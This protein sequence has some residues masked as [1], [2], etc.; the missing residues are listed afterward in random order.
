MYITIKLEPS[1]HCIKGLNKIYQYVIL[2][3][4]FLF[5]FDEHFQWIFI[6]IMHYHDISLFFY[7]RQGNFDEFIVHLRGL[8]NIYNLSGDRYVETSF[9]FLNLKTKKKMEISLLTL[10]LHC[11][12]FFRLIDTR[13]ILYFSAFWFA[14]F[15]YLMK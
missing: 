7:Y 5:I 8:Q 3:L 9:N 11:F 4:V 6:I 15:I 1:W 10:F 2:V 14:W 13:N 12:Q